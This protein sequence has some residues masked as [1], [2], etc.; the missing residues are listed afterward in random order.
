MG[1]EEEDLLAAIGAVLA[2]IG[3]GA[4]AGLGIAALIDAL[5]KA[6]EEE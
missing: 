2:G 5:E 6:R 1:K 3:I 4:L